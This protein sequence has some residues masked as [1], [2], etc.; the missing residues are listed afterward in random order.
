MAQVYTGSTQRVELCKAILYQ[1]IL[2]C[3]SME[4]RIWDLK[5]TSPQKI[6]KIFCDSHKKFKS[7]EKS[8]RNSDFFCFFLL[9]LQTLSYR[10]VVNT[11]GAIGTFCKK[12]CLNQF[13]APIYKKVT[14]QTVTNAVKQTAKIVYERNLCRKRSC[15]V[16]VEISDRRL[17]QRKIADQYSFRLAQK[18]LCLTKKISCSL[19]ELW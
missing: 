4:A 1:Y 10:Q 7:L 15:N 9:F 13:G 16:S 11:G 2:T 3:Y 18:Q 12:N 8:I 6:L 14:N 19:Q 17:K 5:K